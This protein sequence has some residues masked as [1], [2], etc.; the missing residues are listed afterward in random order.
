[1]RDPE[2]DV[3][4]FVATGQGGDLSGDRVGR[5]QVGDQAFDAMLEIPAV[6]VLNLPEQHPTARAFGW[7]TLIFMDQ[8]QDPLRTGEN[9]FVWFSTF[10]DSAAYENYEAALSQS[11]RW[12]DKVSI[13]LTRYLERAPDVLKLSPTARSRLRG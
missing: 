3:T 6:K 4:C 10:Q 1:V 12:R 9:V 5:V 11:E 2:G 7:R 13:G 8:I